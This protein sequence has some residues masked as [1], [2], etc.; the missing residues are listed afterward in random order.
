VNF[1]A[2]ES[3]RKLRGGFYTAPDI[4][5]F[6]A[7]WAG[8]LRPRRVLEP[9]CGDGAF[10]DALAKTGNACLTRVFA[11]EINPEEAAKA[12]E[13]FPGARLDLRVGDF[14]RWFL[15]HGGEAEPFD[16]AL[17]NPPFIRYQYLSEEEQFLAEKV[18]ERFSLPFTRHTNSWVPFVIA[19]L[20]LL[21]PGGRLAMVIP[22]EI[23]HIR[24]AQ[25][26]RRFLASQCGRILLLD[27]EEIWF[28]N[29]LQGTV[30]LLA[31]KKQ[32]CQ[33]TSQGVAVLPIHSRRRLEDDPEDLFT[34]AAYAD[35]S[36]TSGK[37]MPLFLDRSEREL[38]GR[39]RAHARVKPFGDL[40]SVD[41]GIV[42]GANDFFL[43]PDSV[44]EEFALHQ[45]AHPM[46]GRS[47]HAQGLIYSLEDHQA[48]KRAG[49]PANFLWFQ[50][51]TPE[52]LS[53]SAQRYLAKGLAEKLPARFKCAVRT[54]WF[55]V[56][57]VYA[58][59][60]AMLKRAHQYP[61]LVLNQAG[62]YTTDTAYRVR[63]NNHPAE[64]LVFAFVNSLTCLTAELEGRHYGGGVLELV[65]SEIERLLIPTVRC[66]PE[67]LAAADVAFRKAEDALAFLQRQDAI[68]L[69][70]L[71]V[72]AE[73]QTGLFEACAKLRK[74]RRR[75]A[76]LL[77]G[78][79]EA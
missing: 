12:K 52:Q 20:A 37:W 70:D 25:P 77:R 18:F 42:T 39:L 41:V 24:H 35:G 29:T 28:Q 33:E 47:A 76:A 17:G 31:E 79:T 46:F 59:P 71:G 34:S 11:C 64:A 40:A 7:R 66:G 32:D 56:P 9:S 23:L 43:V 26:L 27:P 13:R 1:I 75:A 45:W 53:P 69:G 22:S 73:E 36:V 51:E 3:A 61:R 4:A 62:A 16:A 74:R 55:K 5:A 19:A 50:E 72:S 2:L 6:L 44:V 14:L 38:L 57:S 68:V 65:P 60:I 48:H 58:A 8:V 10:L 63:P 49:L 21:R 78:Q 67:R 30:L 15:F 54:P